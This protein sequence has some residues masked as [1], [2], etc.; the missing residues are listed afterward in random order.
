MLCNVPLW[1]FIERKQPGCAVITTEVHDRDE[2]EELA[3]KSVC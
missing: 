1:R 3:S 2:L